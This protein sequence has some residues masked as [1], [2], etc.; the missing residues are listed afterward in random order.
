MAAR[1][2]GC[3]AEE[4]TEPTTP[5]RRSRSRRSARW[6][7]S[8]RTATAVVAHHAGGRDGFGRGGDRPS[9]RVRAVVL[10]P[11]APHAGRATGRPGLQRGAVRLRRDRRLGRGP[12]GRARSTWRHGAGTS[13]WPPA[14]LRR[15]GVS[16]LALVGLRVGATLALLEGRRA[17]GRR[18]GGVGPGGPRV[19]GTCASCSC[20][21]YRCPR[22]RPSPDGR[23]PSCRPGASSPRRR[24]MTWA[25]WTWPALETV[26]RA[27][28]VLV[29]DRDD[30]PAEHCPARAARPS[31]ACPTDHL[32]AA[33][34][35]RLLDQPTEYATVAGAIVEEICEFVVGHGATVGPSPEARTRPPWRPGRRRRNVDRGGG[36]GRG[37]NALV[38]VMTRPV[39]PSRATVVWLNSGSEHHV[40]P[41]SGL[42]RVRPGRWPRRVHLAAGGLLRMGREPR[43]RSRPGPS[44]RRP[45]RGRGPG[46]SSA[47]LRQ[48]GHRPV[49]VAGLCAGAWIALRAAASTVA[50]DGVIAINPQLYWQ[51]GEPV[52]ADIVAETRARRRARDPSDQEGSGAPAC[53]GCSTPSAAASGRVVAARPRPVRHAG[54]GPVRRRRRRPRVPGGPG[55]RGPGP[56]SG[57]AVTV[58]LV[59]IEDIDHPMHRHW[60]RSEGGVGHPRA[61]STPASR[62]AADRPS[63]AGHGPVSPVRHRH[64]M[65]AVEG[66]DPA[67]RRA[68]A[69]GGP[70]GHEALLGPGG[71]VEPRVRR[72]RSRG[73][74]APPTGRTGRVRTVTSQVPSRAWTAAASRPRSASTARPTPPG[75]WTASRTV[76]STSRS[77]RTTSKAGGPNR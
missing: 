40:G 3:K 17:G 76:P 58:D 38:G 9:R 28:R 46:R 29:V 24:S 47:W 23:G 4:M 65:E 71:Q 66:A 77:T 18:R 63:D 11:D 21:A 2:D 36:P 43:P 39:G 41:G 6:I 14:P 20:W 49:V 25:P 22:T 12:V 70:E 30:K 75:R 54:P 26:P 72:A 42:G 61:G 15:L 67:L 56:R 57:G 16:S 7:G 74:R 60:H 59:V 10:P 34:T 55:R 13:P 32:V 73:G 33:G 35:D 1:G 45:R 27:A 69:A 37:R 64:G 68:V 8:G 48:S 5:P 31:S 51:P 53:G 50:L 44:L 62:T 52:E 19:G